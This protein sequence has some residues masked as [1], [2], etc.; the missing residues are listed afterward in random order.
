MLWKS[1]QQ[2]GKVTYQCRLDKQK[3]WKKCTPGKT[4]RKLKPRVHTFRVRAGSTGGWDKTPA[5]WRWTV[6]K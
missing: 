5:T 6:K 2:K 3:Y 4:Y 1:S